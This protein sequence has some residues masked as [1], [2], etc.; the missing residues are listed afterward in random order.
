MPEQFWPNY[1]LRRLTKSLFRNYS[2]DNIVERQ[3]EL[4]ICN[5]HSFEIC[6][7]S[8]EFVL[9]I[10]IHRVKEIEFQRRSTL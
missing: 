6:S 9:R 1:S 4:S 8:L 3:K 2:P 10:E 7:M 5:W